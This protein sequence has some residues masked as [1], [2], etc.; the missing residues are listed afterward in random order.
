[1]ID[2]AWCVASHVPHVTRHVVKT[3][4]TTFLRIY[5]RT[6]ARPSNIINVLVC[7]YIGATY[8]GGLACPRVVLDFA[9]AR[10][11]LGKPLILLFI[12]GCH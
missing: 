5:A 8:T 12:K 6:G 11:R 1:M 2:S 3:R 7:S 4:H 10:G 9:D